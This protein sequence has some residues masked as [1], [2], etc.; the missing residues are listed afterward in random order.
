MTALALALALSLTVLDGDTFRLP[1]GETIRISNIDAPE[2]GARA[3]CDA[4]RF[5]A[6]HAR[7]GLMRLLGR[8]EPEI[9]RE[10][11]KDRYGRTLARVRVSGLDVGQAMVT[12]ALAVP[13]AGK[14]H[15]WCVD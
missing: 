13:W 9:T 14:R 12:Q 11:R 1:A 8:G 15:Q 5:L 10:P 4:E 7:A 6:I 3:K 2:S